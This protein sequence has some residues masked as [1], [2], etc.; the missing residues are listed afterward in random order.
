MNPRFVG[1]RALLVGLAGL[2]LAVPAQAA[3]LEPVSNWGADGVPSTV[4]MS[5]YVPDNL[6]PNP[7][8]LV[9]CHYCGGK[10]SDVFGQARNGGIVEAADQYG[11][12]MV[13]PQGSNTDGSGRCWDVGSTNA[14]TRYG[15]GDTE[16]IVQMVEYT[17]SQ[18]DANPDRIYVTGDSSGGMMTEALLALYPD[19]FKAGSAFAGVPAGCWAAN[20]PGGGWSSP[21]ANGEVQHTPEEWGA[22][23]DAMYPDYTGHRPRVQLFHGDG[24][25]TIRYPN[26]VEAIDEWTNV[27]G[28]SADPD[29]E[30]TVRLGNHDATRQGWQDSC[31]TVVLDAFTSLGGDHGPSDALF[32][33]DYVIPFLGLDQTGPVDPEIAACGGGAGGAGG[34]GG[35]GE[36]G[37]GTTGGVAEN[38]GEPSLGGATTGGE[39]GASNGGVA[40]GGQQELG[41]MPSFGGAPTGGMPGSGG[42]Q[43][44]GGVLATGG[45]ISFGGTTAMG[46]SVLVAGGGLST[47]G[48][49]LGSGGASPPAGGVTGIGGRTASGGS[50]GMGGAASVGGKPGVGGGALATG[51]IA[52][53]VGGLSDVD[54]EAA[55]EGSPDDGGCGCRMA[56]QH[57]GSGWLAAFGLF[58]GLAFGRSRRGARVSGNDPERA[59]EF[60]RH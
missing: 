31:G 55:D 22:I 19:I 59:T 24:D 6:A 35:A 8:I 37:S 46:G 53:A 43:A 51:G 49:T 4:T 25:D 34:G 15:G 54:A 7:P 56:S 18:Y 10:A 20:N 60:P 14:L 47:G 40:G 11:F 2:V 48:S 42:G 33:A 27:L 32:N 5:I 57:H 38:G 3:S 9:L 36:A 58:V 13:V 21:C 26:H 12:I 41:G 16:A 50:L 52:G 30:E 17:L 1:L 45:T 28:L 23:V 39:S 44:T 29:S